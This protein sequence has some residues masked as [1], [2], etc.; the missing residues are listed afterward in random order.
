MKVLHTSLKTET[1]K[2]SLIMEVT[3][4]LKVVQVAQA[5][6]SRAVEHITH[7]V[8]IVGKPS[9][10]L[11]IINTH[12]RVIINNIKNQLTLSMM[13]SNQTLTMQGLTPA[14]EGTTRTGAIIKVA[15]SR[16]PGTKIWSSMTDINYS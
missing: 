12:L 14:M 8:L 4:A 15:H 16:V 7:L 1:I 11:R 9:T 6:N 3:Q 5:T 13:L 2:K 10:L